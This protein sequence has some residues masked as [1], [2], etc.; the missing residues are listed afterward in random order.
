MSYI[1]LILDMLPSF[2]EIDMLPSF[3]EPE[4]KLGNSNESHQQMRYTSKYF[5]IK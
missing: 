1:L 4:L 5:H 3:T 2:T